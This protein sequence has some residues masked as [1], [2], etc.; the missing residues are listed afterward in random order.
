MTNICMEKT[1]Q[2]IIADTSALVSLATE[3]DHNH[4]PATEAASQLRSSNRPIILPA[5]VFAETIN[6]LGRRSGHETALRAAESF[7]RPESHFI[8]IDTRA[9]IEPALE[10]FRDKPQAVSFTD[11]IVMAVADEY[12]TR[13]IFG[14]DKQFA[15]AGYHRLEPSTNWEEAR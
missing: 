6:I 15:D 7:L 13:D 8:L 14:F 11:C 9:C 2:P 3:T 5:D 4:K 1:D 12:G 10:K